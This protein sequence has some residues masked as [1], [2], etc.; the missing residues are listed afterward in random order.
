MKIGKIITLILCVALLAVSA[1]AITVSFLT[2]EDDDTNTFVFGNVE[3]TLDE[4]KV[5][6]NG[7]PLKDTEGNVIRTNES[8]AY[9]LVPGGEYT[10]DP[11]VTVKKGTSGAYVRILVTVSGYSEIKT[12][13][14]EDFLPENFVKEWD[15]D[16]WN[17]SGATD[18][19]DNT[20]TYEFRY[21]K[22]AEAVDS[23]VVLEPLF[24]TLTLPGTVTIENVETLAENVR[25]TIVAHGMQA[26]GFESADEAWEGFMRQ[27]N[28]K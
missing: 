1:T 23:D 5:D 27:K 18:N 24:K 4:A 25:I 21:H 20:V 14:G 22:I 9:H 19:G 10:K 2:A 11:T 17:Y 28:L 7:V 13:F 8:N 12:V 6:K 16:I 3:I 15:K 26:E